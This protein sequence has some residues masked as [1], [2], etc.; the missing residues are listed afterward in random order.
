MSLVTPITFAGGNLD[1]AAERRRDAAALSDAL[2]HPQARAVVVGD[3]GVLVDGELP[4]PGRDAWATPE[5]GPAR[6]AARVP[7]DGRTL[8]GT[9]GPDGRLQP[10][11]APLLL[12]VEPD[13]A[14]LLAAE[15]TDDDVLVDLRAA[16]AVLSPEESGLL[17]YAQ[18]MRHWHRTHRFC[19]TCGAPSVSRE[20]G[21]MREC[22][23][24]HQVHPRT[25]PVVIML[26]TDA[27]RDRVLMGRQPAWPANR[28]SAL[29]GFIE[30]GESLETAV[31]REVAEEAGIEVN[32]VRFRASQPWPFPASLMIGCETEYARGEPR[33]ADDELE[34]VRWFSRA[35]LLA[36][37]A[38]DDSAPLLLPPS[39]AIARHLIDAWL[40][41][42]R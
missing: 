18:S 30:P 36:A 24:G 20:A 32:G 15:A 31:R 14:P 2:A 38:G 11:A 1:R 23:E 16:A 3:A 35:E 28:W 42:G 5:G 41:D 10:D 29:A 21:H 22:A 8:V 27:E 6:R 7:L 26:V 40:A 12:G 13:G 33:T 37:E 39:I 4:P 9:T 25:D 34:A 19:G 17:A